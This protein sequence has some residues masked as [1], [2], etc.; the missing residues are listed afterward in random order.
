MDE[1]RICR[2]F[3]SYSERQEDLQVGDSVHLAVLP[4][5]TNTR[6]LAIKW[7]GPLIINI[8]VNDTMIKIKEI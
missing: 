5:I 6:K 4:P 2:Q 7:S 8:F 3:E 1:V